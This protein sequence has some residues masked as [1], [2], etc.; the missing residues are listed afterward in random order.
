MADPMILKVAV[1]VPLPGLFDYLPPKGVSAAALT[2]GC[3]LKIPFGNKR[4]IGVLV[5][6]GE[7][8]ALPR[9]KIRAAISVLENEPVLDRP[10]LDLLL[11]AADYY[12]HPAGEVIDAALPRLLRTGRAA[13]E[14]V[15][16]AVLS[17]RGRQV[18]EESLARRAPRQA[19]L[20]ALIGSAGEGV[21]LKQMA[22]IGGDWR[23]ALRALRQ[24]GLCEVVDVVATASSADSDS[25]GDGPE[26]SAAATLT[27]TDA[28]EQAVSAI[29]SSLHEFRSFLLDGVTGSGK[30]E[31]YLRAISEVLSSGRQ[32]L[33]LVPEIGLT[34]QLLARFS[35]RF[36]VDMAVLHSGLGDAER[37]DAWRRAAS[38]S[39]QLIIGT[40]SAVFAPLP[41]PGIIVVDEEH[42]ASFKQQDGFRYS[43]RDLAIMRARTLS[44]PVVLGS[45]TPSLESINN[46]SRQ[47]S[48]RL[49]LPERPGSVSHPTVR[50]LDMRAHAARQGLSTPLI[51]A[52][53]R[54]LEAGTQVLL[55]L[56]RRGYAPALFCSTC[57]WVAPCDRCDARLTLHRSSNRLRCHHCGKE[58]GVPESCGACDQPLTALGQGTERMEETLASLFPDVAVARIDR[59]S[60]RRRGA[61]HRLLEDV[62][63]GRTRILV[64]TQM[65]TKGHHFPNVTLVAV[66]N[67]DQGLFGSDFRSNERFAQT[68]IQVA[69]RAGRAD[70]P[71]EVLI[72]TSFPEHPLLQ[73][74]ISDGY[75]AFAEAALEERKA[76]NWPPYTHLAMLRAEA[77]HQQA[78]YRYLEEAARLAKTMC[79]PIRR[80]PPHV[81]GP[82]AAPMEKR[83]GRYRAQLLLQ[84]TNRERLQAFLRAWAP[85]LSHLS[86]ARKVRWSLDVDPV[87]LF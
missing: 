21:S 87:E 79:A 22:A 46:V 38:G 71:G 45:A 52:I 73:R 41:R 43:A 53:S 49:V 59:D 67:A 56:N 35:S 70:R 48:Q 20:L 25:P 31:V 77:A 4:L 64:G 37:L 34:P 28:Q 65:L 29:S 27:L 50:V 74:L 85:E 6:V 82:A 44:I 60:T 1:P 63:S 66:L 17:E 7:G 51:A 32:A 86:G 14:K 47:R 84:C 30:T 8:S 80:D 68:L 54:H 58:T 19:Q 2:P 75:G 33:L 62:Q 9:S 72:Q 83:A 16:R 5:K 40:R 24:K 36:G 76:A 39:A 55:F 23:G 42:D 57:G 15:R 10:L 78:P 81:L 12:Q 11:W 26:K 69:G 3:R 18:D 13:A 61:M